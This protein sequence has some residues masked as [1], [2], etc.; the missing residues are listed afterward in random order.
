MVRSIKTPSNGTYL[1]VVNMGV[2][3]VDDVA[4]TLPVSGTVRDAVVPLVNGKLVLSMYPA[5]LRSFRVGP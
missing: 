1:A 4:I 2:R 5:Q 3:Q